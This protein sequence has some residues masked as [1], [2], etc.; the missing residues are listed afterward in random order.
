MQKRGVALVTVLFFMLVAIIAAT[1]L[2]KWL[3]YMGDSSAAELKRTEAYQASQAG[4]ETVRAWLQ[5]DANDVGAILGYYLNEKVPVRMDSVLAP[6]QSNK[7]QKFSVYLIAADVQSYPYKLKFVSTGTGRNG[8]RYSQVA[9][10]DLNG[11]FR[12]Y[13]P[14]E[15]SE[16]DFNKAFYGTFGNVTGTDSMES[17]VINGDYKGNTPKVTKSL[18]VTGNAILQGPATIGGA[19]VYIGKD[20][21]ITGTS[22]F[23]TAGSDTIIFYIG[24]NVTNCSGVSLT[25]YGDAYFGGNIAANCKVSVYG[26]ATVNG[27]LYRG[28]DAHGFYVTGNLIF[29]DST[30]R[31]VGS[32]QHNGGGWLDVWAEGNV[33]GPQSATGSGNTM[34][35]GYSKKSVW[36]N[37]TG[38]ASF[39][40]NSS[41]TYGGWGTYTNWSV[42]SLNFGSW[43]TVNAQRLTMTSTVD[44]LSS[45]GVSKGYSRMA[46]YGAYI[47]HDTVAT[48]ILLRNATEWMALA[49]TTTKLCGVTGSFGDND[50][51]TITKLNACYASELT[52]QENTGK[53]VLYGGTFMVVKLTAHANFAS[54]LLLDG[55]FVFIMTGT[56]S[57]RLPA[58]T[59]KSVVMLYLPDGAGDLMPNSPVQYYN[60]FIYSKGNISQFIS[61]SDKAITGGVVMAGGS[62]LSN[63]QG[64]SNFQYNADVVSALADAGLIK[65]NPAY[66]NKDSTESTTSTSD[67]TED[68]Y[69]VS[70]SPRL[71]VVLESE[72]ANADINVD[73]LTSSNSRQN[74][75]ATIVVL[76]RIIYLPASTE[77]KSPLSSF[78]NAMRLNDGTHAVVD[79]SASCPEGVST[80][81]ALGSLSKGIYACTF[82]PSESGYNS[83]K[84]WVVVGESDSETSSTTSSASAA[85]SSSSTAT[86]ASSSGTASSSSV[87]SSSSLSSGS[88]VVSSSDAY[89]V[90]NCNFGTPLVTVG[91]STV[92]NGTLNGV[93]SLT[94]V[95]LRA[96]GATDEIWSSVTKT[97]AHVMQ[98]VPT[99]AG[100]YSYQLLYN[101]KELCTANLTVVAA[102]SSSSV[103]VSSSSAA[104][105]VTCGVST[106]NYDISGESV[107]YPSQTLYFVAKNNTSTASTPSVTVMRDNNESIASGT[108]KDY[109]NWT[110]FSMNVP[111]VGTHTY[112]LSYNGKV[113]CSD[114]I[115]I[116]NTLECSV[117]TD[118]VASG[119]SFTFTPTYAGTCW[120]SSLSGNG[121]S[122]S[123]SNCQSSYTITPTAAGMQSYTYKV[124]NGSLDTA[125]CTKSVTVTAAASSSSS[126]GTTVVAFTAYNTTKAVPC[127]NS[128]DVNVSGFPY[129]TTRVSCSGSFTKTISNGNGTSMTDQY[130]TSGLQVCAANVMPCT[131]IISTSCSSGN[132]LS[133]SVIEQ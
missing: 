22:I 118:S 62:T 55:K 30:A 21:S 94:S 133:C 115:Q 2:F 5:Y 116:K 85:T 61:W 90:T 44:S 101:E 130:N 88:V 98:Y 72:Y 56:S 64:G 23:G 51:G 26:N 48:P 123:T 125:S 132:T 74:I 38:S 104:I 60:Y 100:F 84:F 89:T 128:I 39:T 16:I 70:T 28:N 105:S 50:D 46:S 12:V 37:A 110:V 29:T 45:W 93:S 126:G 109:S 121:V 112:N 31:G 63:S 27:T 18:L 1:A 81:G 108:L 91:G 67:T 4:V 95:T 15:S 53:S 33:I 7:S 119:S 122:S 120:G 42:G 114:D 57:Q 78:Y 87:A 59:K 131:G 102:S 32:I 75:P 68:S 10:F 76:P 106:H 124:T 40:Q 69:Y 79:G 34:W 24:G 73:T 3:K 11:L 66:T 80:S 35:W 83:C 41:V 113:V 127:G 52:K 14:S 82:T 13:Q 129:N 107:F 20:F 58:M 19:D 111:S 25:V 99:T 9:I 97:I 65:Q 36:E 117:S 92:F 86:L 71:K 96:T 103:T 6:L 8:S 54:S 47:K 49:D 77:I 17:A 43:G